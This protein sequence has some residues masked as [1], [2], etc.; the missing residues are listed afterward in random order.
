MDEGPAKV[1]CEHAERCGGCPAIELP[2]IDQL[3]LKRGRVVSALARYVS[4]ELVYADP[5]IAAD[6]VVGYRRRAKLMV[7]PRGAIG[8]FAKGGGHDVIDVPKCRVLSPVVARVVAAVRARVQHDA[9]SGGPLAPQGASGGLRA[10]D[11]REL[12]DLAGSPRALLTLVVHRGLAADLDPL[13]EVAASLL[14]EAPEVVG[15]A[16]SLHDGESPQVLGAETVL[17]AGA[18]EA[19]DRIGKCVHVATFGSF[20]QAHRQQA[21]R[22]HDILATHLGV[23]GSVDGAEARTPRIV[24]LYSGSGAIALAL[25]ARGAEVTC[26]EAFGPAAAR[27]E[28]AATKSG[29]RVHAMHSDVASALRTFGEREAKFEAAVVNPPRRGVGPAAR[30]HL[31]RIAPAVIGYVSCDPDTLARDLDHFARLGYRCASAQPL[32]MIPLSDEVE[33]VAIL[34][35]APVPT[36]RV[37]FEDDTCIFVDKAAHEPTTPQG[38]YASSLLARVRLLP[39]AKEAVPVHRLD[40]GTS[41]VVL[42]ARTPGD[43]ARWQAAMTAAS[44]RKVYLAATRGVLPTKGSVTRDLRDGD[45]VQPARTKYRRLSVFSGHCV[46]RVMPEQ[47]RAHQIRRHLSQVGHPVLGDERYGHA[48]T[49]RHFEEKYGL[50]RTF[51]HCVRFEIEHPRDATPL[52]VESPLPGDLQ[53]VLERAG[54]PGTLRFLDQKNA[55]GRNT[56]S[57]PPPSSSGNVH[58]AGP[59]SRESG[60]DGR[61]I[62]ADIVTDE[63]DPRD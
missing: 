59:V 55:L 62:R 36:P 57:Y 63:D 22:I 13:R 56:S 16:A 20:V 23:R 15:V 47:G 34:R 58:I 26:V 1:E 44:S 8:L 48:P 49:N 9:R 21:A 7:G 30:E 43:V 37:L 60:S 29:I 35:R 17:L 3:S 51:L 54:G 25:G 39:N 33:T 38:E 53:T 14:A 28:R 46:A 12:D 6:P 2:Y 41:G 50:D 4:L 18:S 27:I 10:I 52:V 61:I 42:F 5:V 32:D 11:V 19:D 40:V 24:D 31:A 45:S